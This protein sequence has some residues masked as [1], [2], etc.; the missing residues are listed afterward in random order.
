[1]DLATELE[2]LY[3]IFIQNPDKYTQKCEEVLEKS[4]RNTVDQSYA[5]FKKILEV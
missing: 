1:V 2:K 4:R 3:N 5:D